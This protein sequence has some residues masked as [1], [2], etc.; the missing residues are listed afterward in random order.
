M[1]LFIDISNFTVKHN[2]TP[3]KCD[4]QLSDSSAVNC[5]NTVYCLFK[6]AIAP[7]LSSQR[8]FFNA[9][10]GLHKLCSW[11]SAKEQICVN[12]SALFFR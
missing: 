10:L 12:I 6:T 4:V 8:H 1:D 11:R 7:V 5:R 3:S 2:L 9:R